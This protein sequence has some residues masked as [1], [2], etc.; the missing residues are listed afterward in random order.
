MNSVMR[1]SAKVKLPTCM[2]CG[3][4][5]TPLGTIAGREIVICNDCLIP[6]YNMLGAAVALVKP[7]KP[8]RAPPKKPLSPEEF[9]EQ[10]EKAVDRRKRVL[11]IPF[12][13]R[14]RVSRDVARSV[15]EEL[16]RE[17][18]WT[19]EGEGEKVALVKPE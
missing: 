8:K 14:R 9:K 6:L 11:L 18:G 19:L 12:A 16:V 17:K 15:A 4:L 13:E 10:L 2:I 1:M 3:K 5:G 7:A